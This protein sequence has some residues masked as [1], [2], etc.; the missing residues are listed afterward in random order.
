MIGYQKPPAAVCGLPVPFMQKDPTIQ[1]NY[2]SRS[3]PNPPNHPLHP[4]FVSSG[5]D[6][7]W[8]PEPDGRRRL[9]AVRPSAAARLP[10]PPLPRP[11]PP[12]SR[13]PSSRQRHLGSGRAGQRHRLS[14][15]RLLSPPLRPDPPILTRR[16]CY[17]ATG[18]PATPGWRPAK[19]YAP[20]SRPT[21]A[22][23]MEPPWISFLTRFLGMTLDSDPRA[24]VADLIS[25]I[26]LFG[27]F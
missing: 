3:S 8:D 27:G 26:H 20:L 4:D 22:R 2:T 23:C 17:A 19:W 16:N 11:A 13:R 6:P 9:L 7:T 1:K 21:M 24:S 15:Y 14:S 25:R 5:A 18:R 10:S 12:G